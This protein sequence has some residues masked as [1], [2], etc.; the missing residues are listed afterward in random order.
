M[1][2][3]RTFIVEDSPLILTKLVEMLEEMAAVKVVGTADEE[4]S[5]N[6][7]LLSLGDAV[8]LVIVDIFL[9]SGSGLGVLRRARQIGLR[10][11]LV[12]LTNHASPDMR[13]RCMRLGAQRVFDKSYDIDALID[14]CISQAVRGPDSATLGPPD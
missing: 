1:V 3:L 6:Q 4:E 11:P 7:Q 14:Y 10:A 9:K 2:P 5:A 13:Q 12:V 8:D